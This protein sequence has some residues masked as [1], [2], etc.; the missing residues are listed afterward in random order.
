MQRR[1][2]TSAQLEVQPVNSEVGTVAVLFRLN[3]KDYCSRARMSHEHVAWRDCRE[4]SASQA[5][6]MQ[7]SLQPC[8]WT[9]HD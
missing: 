9:H 5:V 6:A 8:V 1:P 2:C 3:T 4:E 7:A